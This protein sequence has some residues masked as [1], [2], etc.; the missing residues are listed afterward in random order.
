VSSLVEVMCI[1][2]CKVT[3]HNHHYRLGTGTY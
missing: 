3:L 2:T 1:L